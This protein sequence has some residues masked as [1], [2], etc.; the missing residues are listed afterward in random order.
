MG[1]PALMPSSVEF[2]PQWVI[3]PPIEG[4]DRMS[5]CG[6]QPL[7]I[8]LLPVVL[9]SNP[10]VSHSSICAVTFAALITQMNG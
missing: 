1:I 6:A 9:S 7:M 4:C 2:H 5:T 3:K 10:P 8:R